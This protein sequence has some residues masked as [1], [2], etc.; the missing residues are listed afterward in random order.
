MTAL[1]VSIVTVAVANFIL[2]AAGPVLLG[3]RELP[4]RGLAII[5]LLAPAILAALVVTG[6]FSQE[7][8]L[9]AD[10]RTPG[11]AVAG[12]ALLLRAPLLVAIGLG[13]L[14][15]AGLRAAF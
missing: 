11:V 15:A 1:W 8:Q 6:T 14:T 4:A 9:I 13:T 5:A 2:K 3:G 12:A 7:G 10:E